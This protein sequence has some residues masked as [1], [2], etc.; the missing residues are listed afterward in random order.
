MDTFVIRP[1]VAGARLHDPI[2]GDILA[3]EGEEKPRTG[4]WLTCLTRGDVKEVAAKAEAAEP[5]AKK[6]KPKAT[7]RA[8]AKPPAEPAPAALPAPPAAVTEPAAAEGLPPVPEPAPTPPAAD[9]L[10]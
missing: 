5:S 6:A 8:K 1:A 3:A 7:G 2:T 4:F 10:A 9:P